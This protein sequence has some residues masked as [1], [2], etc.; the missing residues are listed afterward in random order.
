MSEQQIFAASALRLLAVSLLL[1]FALP[2]GFSV[3]YLELFFAPFSAVLA[4][5]CLL[6]ETAVAVTSIRIAFVFLF[7][8]AIRQVAS[9]LL[10]ACFG[11]GLFLFYCLVFA[12]LKGWGRVTTLA[13]AESYLFQL[14]HLLETLGYSIW[15]AVS[16]AVFVFG[17]SVYS[18]YAY[19]RRHDWL[20]PFEKAISRN[21]LIVVVIGLS[22]TALTA[23][24]TLE[25]REW[26]K[27][28]E[29][30]SL[31]L[32]PEQ[33]E[34]VMQSHAIEF[35]RSRK[36]DEEDESARK[37]YR[38]SSD[39]R[40]SNVVVIV[41]DALRAD[42]LSLFGYH[43]KTTPNLDILAKTN[44]IQLAT[45]AVAVC[46]ESSCGLR[47]LASSHYVDR[48]A[49]HPITM[50]ELLKRHGY[51]VNLIF[52][53]DHTNFDGLSSI[54]G[55]VDSYFDGFFEKTR[56]LNDD[57]LVV[58]RLKGRAPWDGRPTMFQFH[59]MSSHA[60]GTRFESTPSFGP[61]ENYTR[62]RWG[63]PDKNAVQS[64]VNFYDRGILQADDVIQQ[65]LGLLKDKGYLEE[66]IVVITGDHGESLG[67]RGLYSHTHSVWEESLRVPFIVLTFGK[68][69]TD[70]L[71]SQSLIS[72]VDIA[73]T[74]LH[75]L[76]M[77]I[78]TSWDGT[79]IQN[80]KRPE[81]IFF[82]QA[83]LIGLLDGRTSG[84]LYKHWRDA[85]SGNF[86]TYDLR[87]DPDE[88]F[89]ITE[90]IDAPILEYWAQLLVHKSA[91]LAP[92]VRA[93]LADSMVG[94]GSVQKNTD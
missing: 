51:E 66:A 20:I 57:R 16:V 87:S 72:Q 45:S 44:S 79:A 6:A 36:I 35:F 25:G 13:M 14:P 62:I 67:E 83:Q 43:R 17:A 9:A 42:H 21:M 73:P 40:H 53:G 92:N 80:E 4:H 32:F 41:S 24:L 7:P 86:F 78:P 64:A 8:K 60:L 91:A 1:F 34:V 88:K 48:Q 90:K 93:R 3:V 65:I 11:L 47:A 50:H 68:S 54:Y 63:S 58:D 70:T 5:A 59:L 75:M 85:K 52:S 27:V 28:G 30:I 33:A 61:G 37:I 56:Y 38:P 18:A 10:L 71:V 69:T 39:A 94:V 12:G 49:A 22:A 2:F 84:H 19:L 81:I 76:K 82:Q 89:N 77:P 55:Q 26:G 74:L 46:N 31:S 15:G 23:V 29:P